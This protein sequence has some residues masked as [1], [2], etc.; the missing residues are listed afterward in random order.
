MFSSQ[1]HNYCLLCGYAPYEQM[2]SLF[3]VF[4]F[5]LSFI[6]V[7][8][9][10]KPHAFYFAKMKI[11]NEKV[12]FFSATCL[13]GSIINAKQLLMPIEHM[14]IVYGVC[15][16]ARRCL[17]NRIF[18][19]CTARVHYE[20]FSGLPMNKLLPIIKLQINGCVDIKQSVLTWVTMWL[21]KKNTF[22]PAKRLDVSFQ[23]F[24]ICY[25]EIRWNYFRFCVI[26]KKIV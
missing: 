5:F 12:G 23:S 1:M 8:K 18:G 19:L 20:V 14:T 2:W 10:S 24:Y 9:K 7:K 17:Q 21:F 4:K 11:S 22:E 15:V 3:G 26:E 16:C 13:L 6:F 25:I